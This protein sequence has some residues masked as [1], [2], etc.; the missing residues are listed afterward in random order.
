MFCCKD[1][2][3]DHLDRRS[4]YAIWRS[5]AYQLLREAGRDRDETAALF[6][7]KCAACSNFVRNREVHQLAAP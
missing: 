2:V 5:A 3:V 4:L 6:D 7:A 1:K